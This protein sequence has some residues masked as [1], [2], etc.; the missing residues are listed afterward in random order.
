MTTDEAAKLLYKFCGSE[1]SWKKY[2]TDEPFTVGDWSYATNLKVC[3]RVPQIE[4]K[5]KKR[6][7]V[8]WL[9]FDVFPIVESLPFPAIPEPVLIDCDE[10]EGGNG[11]RCKSKHSG[12]RYVIPSKFCKVCSGAAK[13]VNPNESAVK[14]KDGWY[15]PR[16]LRMV[17][18]LGSDVRIT[19]IVIPKL[20]K[21]YTDKPILFF[22]CG[23]VQGLLMP[24][25][26]P[27]DDSIHE[28]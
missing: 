6:P 17:R 22:E 21:D 16:L 15:E 27:S 1:E 18:D 5:S 12:I 9:P 8:N 24:I 14:V 25:A 10:C 13:V 26:K 2:E 7:P 20:I 3:I 19:E 11:V 23:Q 28:I 4:I